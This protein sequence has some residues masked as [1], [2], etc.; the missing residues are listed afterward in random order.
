[1]NGPTRVVADVLKGVRRL[2]RSRQPRANAGVAALEFA[3]YSTLILVVLAGT[4]DLGMELYTEFQLDNAVNAGA[5]YVMNN[6]A[7]VGT[8]PSTLSSTTQSLVANSNGAGW[9]TATV[10]VN[11]SN[12]SSGCYCPT[13][14]P[15]NWTWGSKVSC[16][17]SC[18]GSGV[19]GQFVTITA[20]RPITPLFPAFT[21]VQSGSVSRHALIE[22]E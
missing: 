20:S 1:M 16:G 18:S 13:G 15:G 6:A 9:A 21:F 12:D 19:G 4:L 8:S 7:L 22:T 14:T 17:S 11:N 3:L 10:N 2:L 5:Q